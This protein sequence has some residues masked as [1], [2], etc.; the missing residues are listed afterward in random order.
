MNDIRDLKK[1][2][3]GMG[4]FLEGKFDSLLF[5]CE[6][7]IEISVD[8]G[9]TEEYAE[10][11]VQHFNSLNNEM[12][13]KI[14]EWVNKFY[15]YTLDEIDEEFA[16]EIKENMLDYKGKENILEYLSNLHMY[17][18][19]PKDD[20]IG[21]NIECDCPWE[22][23]QQCSII[24]RENEVLYIGPSEGF[25]AWSDGEFFCIWED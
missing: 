13:E 6:A 12:I 16:E 20:R 8:E 19:Y 3:N 21:Y 9:T 17:V 22:P 15:L 2:E 25:N 4:G 14:K 23:E 11:C 1:E 7:T 5:K 10:K 18:F 24:I